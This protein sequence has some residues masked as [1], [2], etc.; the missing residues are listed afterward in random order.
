MVP[1]ITIELKQ[2]L[3]KKGVLEINVYYE[4]MENILKDLEHSGPQNKVNLDIKE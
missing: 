3:H 1:N 2:T 4:L